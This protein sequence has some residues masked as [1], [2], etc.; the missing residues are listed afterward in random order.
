MTSFMNVPLEP[1]FCVTSF[2]NVPLEHSTLCVE[3]LDT[4]HLADITLFHL[5]LAQQFLTHP[6]RLGKDG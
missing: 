3:C 4:R 1:P 2:I 6:K 5:L